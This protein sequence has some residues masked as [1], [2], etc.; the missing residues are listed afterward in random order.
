M[1]GLKTKKPLSEVFDRKQ[2]K[3]ALIIPSH[4]HDD[5]EQELEQ[6]HLNLL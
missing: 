5:S 2:T 1:F 6:F 3:S 4:M